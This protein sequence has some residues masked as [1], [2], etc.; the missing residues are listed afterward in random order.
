MY[1][2][3]S[4]ALAKSKKAQKKNIPL[5]SDNVFLLTFFLCKI[6]HL[7]DNIATENGDHK[8]VGFLRE[9]KCRA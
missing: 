7:F 1:P 6:S 4:I 2:L 3:V 8:F 5:R 9:V